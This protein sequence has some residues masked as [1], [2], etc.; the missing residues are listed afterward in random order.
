MS[1]LIKASEVM[2]LPV[3]TIDGGEDVAEVKDV[4]YGSEQG[5]LL[6][7]TLNKRGFLS[8]KMKAVLPASSVSAIGPAAVMIDNAEDCLVAKSE[9]PDAVSSPDNNRNVLGNEVITESGK[10]L[11]TV[12][13]LVMLLGGDGEVVGYELT[14]DD[15]KSTWFIPRPA[16]LALSGEALLVPDDIETYVSDDFSGFGS[17][18]E[19]FRSEHGGDR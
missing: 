2:T 5:R 4:V 19:R 17:S 10:K 16:Q 3:V 1:R 13:D 6:G 8:G 14:R 9:A 12:R 7:L 15:S 18:V 11:G